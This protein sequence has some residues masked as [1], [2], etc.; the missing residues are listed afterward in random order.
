[1]NKTEFLQ[2]LEKRLKYI[3]KEDR[4]D[5]I[6]YY[7]EYLSEMELGDAEDVTAKLGTPKEVAKDIL[8]DVTAKAIEEQQEAK[9]VKGS[10]KIVW[11]VILG[12]ASLPVSIP[13]ACVVLA[14]SIALLA[15]VFSLMLAFTA[16]SL[17]LVIAGFAALYGAIIMPGFATKL[18]WL[19]AGIFLIGF[20]VLI[21]LGTIELFKLIIKLI[22]KLFNKKNK[23]ENHE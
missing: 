16:V 18:I 2:D 17:S 21:F 4:E 8:S 14:L 19:G 7:T 12:I 11:L 9:S 5:A 3:P 15:T 13:I 23:G 1:M 6:A 22:G 10:G 20:G